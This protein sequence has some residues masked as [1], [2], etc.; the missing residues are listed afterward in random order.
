MMNWQE[1]ISLFIV[2]VA[3]ILLVRN[4]MQNKKNK[5]DCGNCTLIEIKERQR[6]KLRS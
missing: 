2:A 5:K 6:Y 3:I 1:I 4:E